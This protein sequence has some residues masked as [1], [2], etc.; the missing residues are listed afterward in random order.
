MRIDFGAFGTN[1]CINIAHTI[2]LFTYQ[3][4]NTF[5]DNLTVH[6]ERFVARVGEMK[7][8]IAHVCSAK[9]GITDG[10]QEHIGITMPQK[11]HGMVNL[12]A[13]Q[14]KVTALNKFVDIKAHAYSNHS[15]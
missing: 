8:N 6:V 3:F 14:P 7:A 9:K 13:S 4:D 15:Y 2:P 12:Y 5:Q 10:M 11:S 1:R